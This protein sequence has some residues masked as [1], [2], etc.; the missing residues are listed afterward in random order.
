MHHLIWISSW[1]PGLYFQTDQVESK[2][3][4]F[5]GSPK[6][7]KADVARH[8]SCFFLGLHNNGGDHILSGTMFRSLCSYCALQLRHSDTLVFRLPEDGLPSGLLAERAAW[9]FTEHCEV[10]TLD[11]KMC[12]CV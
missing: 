9:V 3:I 8:Q 12:V 10:A 5:F 1:L 7:E 11:G 4:F 2:V 6:L